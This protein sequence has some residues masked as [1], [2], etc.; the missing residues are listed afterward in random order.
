MFKPG[1]LW[2][3]TFKCHLLSL[4][5]YLEDVTNRNGEILS[6]FCA[7]N[8]LRINNTYFSHKQQHKYTFYKRNNKSIIDHIITNRMF[9]PQQT[10]DI[11]P[12]LTL[13]Q[14]IN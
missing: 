7:Q 11:C 13:E 10:V 14:T 9:L 5:T 1:R 4:G 3:L 6:E 8:E 2:N 12:Q